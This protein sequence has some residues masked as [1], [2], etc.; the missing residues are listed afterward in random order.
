MYEALRKGATVE[1]LHNLTYIGTWFINEMKELVDFEE[2]LLTYNWQDL[3]DEK[4]AKAK[5]FGFADRYLAGLFDVEEKK[6]REKRIAIGKHE[7]YEAVPVSGVENAAYY[8]S[9]YIAQDS[10]DVSPNKKMMI[11]GGGPIE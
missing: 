3:S 8:Y 5:E 2:E 6:V 10:V 7:R 9:T 1:E 4:L 11:L